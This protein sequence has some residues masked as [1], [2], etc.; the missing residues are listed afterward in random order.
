MT[1]LTLTAALLAGGTAASAAAPAEVLP[2]D[3]WL[4]EFDAPELHERWTVLGEVAESWS[5]DPEGGA[6]T[7]GSLPGDTY[8]TDNNA[9]NVFVVDVPVGD[10][11]AVTSFAAPAVQDFQGAGLIALADMDNYVRA[12]LAHVGFAEG[13][14]VVIENDLEVGGAFTAT[15]TPRPGS[16]GET[17]RLER[18]GDTVT[19]SYWVDGAWVEAA[20]VTVGFD[21]TQV[22][23]YALAPAGA[24][25][26]DAVFD[27]FAIAPAEPPTEEPT[28]PEPVT[29]TLDIDGDGTDIEMSPDLYGIFYED[30]NYAAD[31][32]LY[33]EL[34]R[35]RSFEFAAADNSS[36]NGLTGWQTVQRGGATTT[37]TV[38]DDDGRMNANNRAYLTLSSSG[39]GAGIRNAS[40]NEGVA[41]EAGAD[42]DFSV[43]ARATTPQTLTAR[44]EDVAGTQEYGTAT[45]EV[46]GSNEWKQYTATITSSGTTNAARLAVLAGAAGVLNLDMVSLMP[47][48]QWVGPVNGEY[49]L[50]QD[51][52]QMVADLEPSFIRFPGGC[53]IAGTWNSYEES[54][55]SDRRRAFHWKETIGGL[56]ERATNFNWW[57]YNQTFGIGYLEFFKW[58]EDL[59][60]EP[61]PVVPVGTNACGGPAALTDPAQLDR[62]VQD[63]LDLIEFANGDVDTEWGAVRA[64]LGHPEPFDLKYIGL[65]NEDSQR[66]YFDNYPIFHDAIREAYPDINIVAN[67]SFASGG[68]LFD[69]LWEFAAEQGSDV[70]DEHYYNPPDWFLANTERYDSYDRE[71]P[72]VF[73]GEY[74]SQGNT[75]YNALAEAAYLTG[76]ERNSDIVTLASYAPLLANEDY[77]QWQN[78]NMIYFD[79]DEL[80]GTVNYYVQRLFSTN[81]GHEV[82][83]S[84]LVGGTVEAPDI[85][86]G[87]FLSTWRTSAAYDNLVVTADDGEVLLSEDF[88]AGAASWTPVRGTWA[89]VDGQYRQTATSIEDARSLPAGAYE[90][91]WTNYTV[92]LEATKLGGAEGFLVGFAANG[93][94]DFYW[95]NLGGWNNTRSVLERANGARQGEVA[96]GPDVALTTGQT[97]DV[98]VEVDGRDIR[99]YLDDVLH[100]EYTEAAPTSTLHHVV[101]RD[102][103]AGELIV[104]V[105]NSG[106]L[107]AETDVTISD[108]EL[109]GA[110][111][112]IEM[113]APSRTATNSKANPTNVVPVERELTGLGN[114]L[115]YEFPADSIT[116]L[117]IPVVDDAGPAVSVEADTRCV[118]GRVVQTVRVTNDSGAPVEATVTSVYGS[119]SVTTGADRATSLTFSTRAGSVPAG[120]VIVTATADGATTTVTAPHAARTCG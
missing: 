86:G 81:R 103:E 77:V 21:I 15:F 42:Y 30:I 6:L 74:A 62:W 71:G 36:F 117:R 34:V 90:Q 46:D 110:G 20:E 92:E 111:T 57:G 60:A 45:V 79:N 31:G 13:G 55:Y 14:P 84:T 48:D 58:A 17:L 104:K 43:W 83:P 59:D 113:T 98:R 108:V 93:G 68:A 8:Q 29:A 40:Y 11:T 47:D 96:A 97:Y 107:P 70:V 85:S 44:L 4:D 67:S 65:G 106:A 10:F 91:D 53:V 76:V 41:L 16:T 28:G 66:Q 118:V 9:Q 89:V 51:L 120:E 105:V 100:L 39:A 2:P 73:I 7:I 114:E 112:V 1:A 69:E 49:G 88:S 35:N 5:I 12:G 80:W 38:A 75:F 109:A 22:G 101:T 82:V 115:T 26:H 78:A 87:V 32:G 33:A 52:A 50:R 24:P 18:V 102:V 27:Y 61:I 116:F 3:A 37:A 54:D 99:L 19:T 23:L 56:E 95:W 25:S 72:E 63:T 64:E 94:Q 119:R